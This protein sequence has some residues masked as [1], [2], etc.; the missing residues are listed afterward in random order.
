M[1][2]VESASVLGLGFSV[3]VSLFFRE[4]PCH[5][6]RFQRGSYKGLGRPRGF[7][8]VKGPSQGFVGAQGL[9]VSSGSGV[10]GAEGC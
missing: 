3:S 4:S 5:C 1:Y 7:V 9:W 10:R 2:S 8:G 6:S